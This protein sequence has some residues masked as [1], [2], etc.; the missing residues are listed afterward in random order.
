VTAVKRG[1]IGEPPV[2][3]EIRLV[4]ELAFA[5]GEAKT[6]DDAMQLTLRK[7]CETTGW[8]V[9]EAWMGD[10]ELRCRSIW[11]AGSRRLER[12]ATE[13][14]EI[15]VPRGEGLMGR[16]WATGETVWMEDVGSN[17]RFVRA[18]IARAAGL[19]SG[20]AVP[21]HAED[22]VAAVLVFFTGEQR[23]EE[24]RLLDLVS[25]VAAQ[26]GTLIRRKQLEDAL[27]RTDEQ[28][29]AV[30]DTAVDVIV[31]A[32]RD[33]NITYLNKSAEWTFGYYAEELLGRPLTI[34]M[35]ERFHAAHGAGFE[36]F[37]ETGETRVIGRRVEL[38]G[39]RKDGSEFPVELAVSSWT[40]GGEIFFTGI[41]RDITERRRA[42]EALRLSDELKTA[43]LR[44]VSH[45]LRSPLTAIVTAGES[46]ALPDL[47]VKARA[48][49]SS[50]IVGEA[51][52]LSRL[53]EKLL[54]LSRLQAGTALPRPMP[55]SIEEVVYTALEQLRASPDSYEVDVD[56]D[57]PLVSA[58][59]AQMERV[60]ANLLENARRFSSGKPFRVSAE[61]QGDRAVVRISDRGPGIP[62]F[63][64]ERV[65][66]AFYRCSGADAPHKGSGL[67]LAIVKGFVES[68]GGQV[69]VEQTPGGG[70][71][72]VVELPFEGMPSFFAERL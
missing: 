51:S 47:D 12:F 68:N 14:G 42:Q 27:A 50:V 1:G 48:E 25:A 60:F 54:D 20:F 71:T 23:G 2:E 22:E 37:L 33:G 11:H 21:V 8:E 24:E 28:L 57:L 36:R 7:I 17:R 45:D 32:D 53:V 29:R 40:E 26:L 55:C 58:D 18:D 16:A 10:D 38:A 41:L 3:E 19:G 67:G 6:V 61:R 9:G 5:I 56:P 15:P 63:E 30:A 72:F 65:F 34:L 44:S 13:T 52:R 39:L 46:T 70:A 43:L 49:L 4:R 66:E 64:R 62:E 59:P 69:R 35:P 31:S